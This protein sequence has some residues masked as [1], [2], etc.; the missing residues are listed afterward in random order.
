MNKEQV[1]IQYLKDKIAKLEAKNAVIEHMNSS[2][3]YTM[4]TL[5]DVEREEVKERDRFEKKVK[6]LKKKLAKEK[7]ISKN[8]FELAVNVSKLEMKDIED[9]HA[10]KYEDPIEEFYEDNLNAFEKE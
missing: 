2:F 7:R 1:F 5:L 4:S 8:F 10:K 3:K 6:S 9:N